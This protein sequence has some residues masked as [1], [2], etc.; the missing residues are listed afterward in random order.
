MTAAA[1]T[2]AGLLDAVAVTVADATAVVAAAP[3]LFDAAAVTTA[4]AAALPEA[5]S[6]YHQG[7]QAGLCL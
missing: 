7:S 4:A 1:V 5:A 2:A 3:P 6:D